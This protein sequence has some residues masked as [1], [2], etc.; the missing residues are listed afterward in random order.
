MK[1][2][3][4]QV[5]VC[6]SGAGIEPAIAAHLFEPFVTSKKNGMGLGLFVTRSIVESHGGKIWS[7]ANADGG[8]TFNFTLPTEK[9]KQPKRFERQHS[10]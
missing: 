1:P 5:S 8:A 3:W 6:D 9:A 7:A 10:G 2:G 4:A